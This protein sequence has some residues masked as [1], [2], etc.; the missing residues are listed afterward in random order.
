MSKSLLIV[1]IKN[2][3]KGKVKTRLAKDLGDDKALEIYKLLLSHTQL[4]TKDLST[5]KS[6][7][8]SEKIEANDIWNKNRYFKQIQKGKDLGEKMLNAFQ[9]EFNNQYN[10]ICIIGCDCYDLSSDVIEMAF[11][12]LH[13]H[14]FVIG[15]ANDG[16]YY[17]IGMNKFTP[18]IF[19]NKTYSTHHVFG[20]AIQEIKKLNKSYFVLPELTDIDDIND[21]KKFQ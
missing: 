19:E 16:G 20:E 18:Q 17:L 7:Y 15:P 21:L 10:S 5:S 11:E 1:F 3:V 6:I 8:Y 14:D 9:D 12:S 2:T 13:K 4:I